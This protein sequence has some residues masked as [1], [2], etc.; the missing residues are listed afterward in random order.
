[1]SQ[2]GAPTKMYRNISAKPGLRLEN[3]VTVGAKVR[4]LYKD[5]TAGPIREIQVGSSYWSQNGASTLGSGK[6]VKMVV[7]EWPDGRK[8]QLATSNEENVVIVGRD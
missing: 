4:V 8:S 7:I 5:G 1:M 2:N 3:L 6:K